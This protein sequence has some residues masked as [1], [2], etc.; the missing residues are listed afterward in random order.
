MIQGFEKLEE[1][2]EHQVF[3]VYGP[4][5][6]ETEKEYYIP[7]MMND[8]VE[9]Y[10]VL[11]NCRLIGEYIPDMKLTQEMQLAE[12][13]DGYILAV[14]QG[15]E[16]AFTLHFESLE[17]H[18]QC[19]Q[20]H[21][22]GHFWVKGQEQWRQLVYMIGTIYDKYTYLGEAVCNEKEIELLRLIEFAPFREWSPI[23]DSLEEQY[24]E[25]TQGIEC[26]TKLAKEAGDIAYLRWISLYRRIPCAWLR[27][28]LQKRLLVPRREELYSLIYDKVAEASLLY[29]KRQYVEE[30]RMEITA[31]QK[32]IQ[33]EFE[34]KGFT[35]TYPVYEKGDTKILVTEEHPFTIMEWEDYK[36]CVQFMVSQCEKP[37][38]NRRNSGFF[39]GRGRKGWIEKYDEY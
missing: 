32:K 2:F 34:E 27:R 30:I 5:S 15:N 13:K 12:C 26:M 14:R 7:Y 11:K 29:P 1:I 23:H 28:M 38:K 18:V 4:Y 35:G 22:I 25:T 21:E 17:E 37:V 33:K 20:Y 31:V 8:A 6:G 9:C 10:L 39:K 24:P 36:F 16:N 19:Y 3:E